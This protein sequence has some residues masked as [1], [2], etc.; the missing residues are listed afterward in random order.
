[1]PRKLAQRERRLPLDLVRYGRTIGIPGES[2][3]LTR[4]RKEEVMDVLDYLSQNGSS[5]PG[6]SPW[7]CFDLGLTAESGSG[8]NKRY[9]ITTKGEEVLRTGVIP[10]Q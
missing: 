2:Y 1:M 7:S 8:V 10:E 3:P 5:A 4:E 9:E 6:F